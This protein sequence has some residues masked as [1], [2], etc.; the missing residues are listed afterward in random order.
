MELLRFE[1]LECRYGAREIFAGLGGVLRD[2]ER[3][4][5][6]GPNGA[7]KSSLLR[8]L[9]G[10]DAP[11]GGRIVRARDARMGYLA[12][13]VADET[14][15]TLQE[16]VDGALAR[17]ANDEYDRKRKLLRTMLAAFG[18][19]PE[20]YARPLR[21]FSGGQRSKGALAH[22]LIDEP[23][24]L[25][26]DEPTN[27]LDIGT[28]RWLENTIAADKRAYLIVSHDRYFIDR[29]A[30]QIWELDRGT[31]YVYPPAARAYTTYLEAREVRRENERRAYETYIAERDKRRAT[32]AGLRATHTSSDYKQVR[33]RERQLARTEAALVA[34][35]PPP[36]VARINVAL[37]AHRRVTG[38]FAFELSGLTKGYAAPL[39][40]GLEID[41]QQGERIAIVGPN[42]A[43]KSTL[44]SILAGE[45]TPDAGTVRYNPAARVAYFAQ[46]AQ[47][48]L[49]PDASAIDAVLSAGNVPPERARGLLGRIGISGEMQ[50]RPVRSFSGGERRR[51]MLARLMAQNADV[52]LLDEPTNDLD[53][54]SREAL[55]S[56][57]DEYPG[58]LVVVS[59]DRYL[60]ARLAERVLW[61]EDG[62]WGILE[63][64]D[65]YERFVRAREDR[66]G[67]VPA[68]TDRPKTTR[69]T[70]LKVRSKLIVQIATVE[71][72]I[73]AFD[74][75]KIEI[76]ALFA[77]PD[78]YEDRARVKA[79]Q[80]EVESLAVR[81]AIAL[82]RWEELHAQLEATST[83][84]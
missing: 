67:N 53:I 57:L 84:E 33:S 22:L 2:G 10:V 9:A 44:L 29:I 37:A 59:H 14:E 83:P 49:D 20:E 21:E 45:R 60:L 78:L 61:I 55:E 25:I 58:T 63:G 54:A 81:S 74:A 38:G 19:A 27:H 6:V 5:L 72:E 13:S 17:V 26:L 75:R 8:L 70:P 28:V 69:L 56:V 23:D 52:L 11:N 1:D 32:I 66:V 40:M 76:D 73:A 50:E 39:F 43:G 65:A 4:A 41:V 82:A 16:L 31:L 71:R 77:Q 24:Y 68:E 79:L 12:Q 62:Q 30:T 47:E 3:I 48:Q 36:E 7:G 64:Y 51:I 18:F 34:P 42:G 15:A 35:E 46:N 80:A